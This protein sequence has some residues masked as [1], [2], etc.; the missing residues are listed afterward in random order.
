MYVT[1]NEKI[2]HLANAYFRYHHNYEN[3]KR[4]T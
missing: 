1:E 4:K 2:A 3:K